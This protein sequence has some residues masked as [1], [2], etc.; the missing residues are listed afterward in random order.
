LYSLSRLNDKQIGHIRSLEDQLGKRLLSFTRH[1]IQA[2]ELNQ[3]E[4]GKLRDL[5]N[6]LGVT[7]VAVK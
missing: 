3:E 4:L 6:K 7:L 1:D 5:E 2:V